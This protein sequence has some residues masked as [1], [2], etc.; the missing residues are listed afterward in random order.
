ML[1]YYYIHTENMQ[2]MNTVSFKI[3]RSDKEQ[4]QELFES[5]GLSFSGAM[6]LF[7]KACINTHGIPFEIKAPSYE[8]VLRNRLKEAEDPENLSPRFKDVD[9]MMETL[10]A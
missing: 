10:D 2:M 9:S 5:M 6:N 3:D 7:I 1:L 4:A 8:Q